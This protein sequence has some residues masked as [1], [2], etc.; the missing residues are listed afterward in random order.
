LIAEAVGLIPLLITQG[1]KSAAANYYLLTEYLHQAQN[2]GLVRFDQ[3]VEL[4][5]QFLDSG[6]EEE[7]DLAYGQTKGVRIMNLHK[8]KGLEAPVVLLADPGSR[9]GEG[10]DLYVQRE[11]T[12]STGWLEV[13][14]RVGDFSRQL[15][16]YPP[17]WQEQQ[18]EEALYQ[19]AERIRLLYVAATRAKDMLVVSNYTEKPDKSP[20]A[21]LLPYLEASTSITKAPAVVIDKFVPVNKKLPIADFVPQKEARQQRHT[22]SQVASSRVATVTGTVHQAI[23]NVP[24]SGRGRGTAWGNAV[25]RAL[26]CLST[27]PALLNDLNWLTGI[28]QTADCELKELPAFQELLSGVMRLEFWQRIQQAQILLTEVPFGIWENDTYLKG[29][30]DLVIREETGWVIADYKSDAVEGEAALQLLIERY[31]P[32]VELYADSWQRLTGEKVIETGI[33]FTDCLQWIPLE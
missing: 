26:E 14:A 22:Q 20:W 3:L 10:I 12:I 23:T 29:T 21:N 8:A 7:L 27:R 24:G 30:I 11:G 4:M 15:L 5:S 9:P 6:V 32:Q 28:L 16:A 19:E 31:R 2:H 18:Q 17:G 33:L 1:G 13:A 25:H